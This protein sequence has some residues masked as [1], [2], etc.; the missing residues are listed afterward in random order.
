MTNALRVYVKYMRHNYFY[1]YI[2]LDCVCYYINL[3]AYI[4]L[5]D[6]SCIITLMPIL[7]VIVVC[8]SRKQKPSPN[9]NLSKPE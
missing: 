8:S 3:F 5:D 7:Q 9:R 2:F 1:I 4:H 6:T